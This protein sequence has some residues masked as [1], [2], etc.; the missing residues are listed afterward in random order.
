MLSKAPDPGECARVISDRIS[1][2]PVFFFSFA[3]PCKRRA[4][5][6]TGDLVPLA[7]FSA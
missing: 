5:G 6:R 7:L 2:G 4:T 3:D 1:T